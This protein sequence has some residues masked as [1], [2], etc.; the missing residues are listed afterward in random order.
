MLCKITQ[1]F[2]MPSDVMS[3]EITCDMSVTCNIS[4]RIS[5]VTQLDVTQLAT[6]NLTVEG[7]S[8]MCIFSI[9]FFK[10]N[11]KILKSLISIK[12]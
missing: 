7:V 8:G 9:L 1:I 5:A 2:V 10:L 11:I 12:F 4:C 3:H 6:E